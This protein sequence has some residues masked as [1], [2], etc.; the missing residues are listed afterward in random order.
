MKMIY[1]RII[2]FSVSLTVAGVGVG[3]YFSGKNDPFDPNKYSLNDKL[4]KNQ[5]T[6]DEDES[7]N[8]SGDNS[9][10]NG[11]ST[12]WEKDNTADK[13]IGNNEK[14]NAPVLFQTK[15]DEDKQPTI[16]DPEQNGGDDNN[17]STS[18]NTVNRDNN[19]DSVV[20]DPNDNTYVISGDADNADITIKRHDNSGDNGSIT[21]VPSNGNGGNSN[22]DGQGGNNSRG[23]NAKDDKN[24][25][26]NGGSSNSGNN[27]NGGNSNN[28]NGGNNNNKPS[29]PDKPSTPD[30]PSEPVYDNNYV[31]KEPELPK[32][33]YDGMFPTYPMPDDG[34]TPDPDTGDDIYLPELNVVALGQTFETDC[35]YYGEKLTPWVLLC[36]TNVHLSYNGK[37]YR[38]TELN[39]NIK[40][41]DYP[42][43]ATE[44]FTCKFSVR[45]NENS[46]WLTQEVSFTV[47]PCKV[48]LADFDHTNYVNS[49]SEQYPEFGGTV[50]LL[51]YY[52]KMY[53]IGDDIFPTIGQEITS[54]FPGWSENNGGEPVYY[55]YEVKN[56]GLNVLY[57]L[58]KTKLPADFKAAIT[59]MWDSHD[60]YVYLQTIT[61]YTGKNRNIVI[62]Q[63][64]HRVDM[65]VNVDSIEI[66]ASV[67]YVNNKMLVRNEYK[68]SEKSSYFALVNGMLFNKD[69]TKLIDVPYE[70][71]YVSVPVTVKTVDLDSKNS[72]EN[73]SFSSTDVP[74]VDLSKLH[75]ADIYVPDN[76]YLKYL[77]KWALKL[78]NN[79]LKP[80][81]ENTHTNYYTKD[82]AILIDTEDGNA[83]CG[84]TENVKG[85]YVVPEG[86]TE[87]RTGAFEN[88]ELTKVILPSTL[89]R[90]DENVLALSESMDI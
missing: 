55:D 19:S 17:D 47:E 18:D 21:Y 6:F 78:G 35:I 82:D 72:I 52:Q 64:I 80:Q 45:L 36:A 62:P 49:K 40:I 87:I 85:V 60:N 38:L 42:E 46:K 65:S 23:D 11:E 26:S 32:D 13:T 89:K 51:K 90:I 73:I 67:M 15:K 4:N 63:G 77:K 24:H 54:V 5:I 27:E 86:V 66:P 8:V 74:D 22:S 59:T 14:P 29:N 9:D 20:T 81:S 31:E 44:D 71:T 1:K 28:G 30:K 7:N 12:H 37:I 2:A 53:D 84:V 10:N 41:T 56:K 34:I 58:S 33:I 76:C 79:T 39:S 16:I 48:I 57:P 3:A 68:V 50:D 88:S 69:I 83:L 43:T 25:N 75:G 61:D 70:K